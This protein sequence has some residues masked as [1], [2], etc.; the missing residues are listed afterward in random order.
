LGKGEEDYAE[1]LANRWENAFND[2]ALKAQKLMSS[3]GKDFTFTNYLFWCN[4]TL[5]E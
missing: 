2:I 3:P 1:T 4:F 5:K